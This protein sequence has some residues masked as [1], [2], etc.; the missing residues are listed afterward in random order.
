MPP[1]KHRHVRIERT[2][3]DG[4]FRMLDRL[5]IPSRERQAVTE[6]ATGRRRA[7]IE[8]DRAPKCRDRLLG[9]P[10]HH[11]QIAERDLSPWITV[12]ERHRANGVLAAGVQR[13]AAI[14]PAHM[15]G[16]YQ[17][18][19]PAGFGPARNPDKIATVCFKV[20]IAVA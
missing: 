4:L 5:A 8:L 7:R 20:S 1:M 9:A 14:D 19:T 17:S 12:V 15:G 11:G 3:P 6:I 13:L 18:E 16:K 10:F 2:E